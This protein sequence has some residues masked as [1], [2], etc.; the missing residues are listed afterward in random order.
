MMPISHLPKGL[1][2]IFT[3]ALAMMC[4]EGATARDND[5]KFIKLIKKFDVAESVRLTP[6]DSVGEFWRRLAATDPTHRRFVSEMTA[7]GAAA[8][9]ALRRMKS[10]PCFRPKEF[11]T[12]DDSL[13]A[14]ARRL[15]AIVG[16]DAW[17]GE[18]HFAIND[19]PWLVTAPAEEGFAILANR[20][21]L[22]DVM[23]ACGG[24]SVSPMLVGVLAHEAVHGVLHHHL[25][26]HYAIERRKSKDVLWS[27]LL[28]TFA[29]HGWTFWSEERA[30]RRDDERERKHDFEMDNVANHFDSEIGLYAFDFCDEMVL[31]AD[32]VAYRF[33]EWLGQGGD[34]YIECLRR[35]RVDSADSKF[36][37]G[38]DELP[39]SRRLRIALLEFMRDHPDIDAYERQQRRSRRNVDDIYGQ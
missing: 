4:A 20:G 22:G 3:I 1:I 16:F 34:S 32:I 18:L 37:Y 10:T 35:L 38:I 39:E 28:F 27:A 8:K 26:Q 30:L 2:A 21:F 36:L 12:L 29:P 17:H 23:R 11:V 6:R 25:Q 13:E 33:M 24:D 19:S 14:Y 5:A 15:S 7:R 9:R 31:Q